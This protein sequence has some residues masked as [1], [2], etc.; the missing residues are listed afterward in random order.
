M[1]AAPGWGGR[2]QRLASRVLGGPVN[3]Q[4]KLI[5]RLKTTDEPTFGR[6]QGRLPSQALREML[7]I[8]VEAVYR[9]AQVPALLLGGAKDIQCDPGDVERIAT[10][11]GRLATTV[12]VPDLT[13]LLRRDTGHH[14]FNS[15]AALVREPMDVAVCEHVW[16]WLRSQDETLA[17]GASPGAQ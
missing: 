14:T 8:D 13:H 2:L 9:A 3:A 12:V 11:L 6:G 4:D 1:A 17:P 16:R 5:R 10:V 7:A 15:Y